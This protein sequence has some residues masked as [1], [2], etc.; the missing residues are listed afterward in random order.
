MPP[1]S[2]ETIHQTVEALKAAGPLPTQQTGFSWGSLS[3][4][5]TVASIVV[6]FLSVFFVFLPKWKDITNK[7][8]DTLDEERRADMAE[9]RKEVREIKTEL[10]AAMIRAAK[11]EASASLADTRTAILGGVISM[12][13]A[14]I[15]RT[16]PGNPVLKQA[17][18]M[19]KDA[20]SH[21]FGLGR[22]MEDI[23]AKV[24]GL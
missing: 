5:A 8:L 19:L 14:E 4:W 6:G 12:L 10:A 21:D 7:R 15:Q 22:G 20:A 13:T 1:V 2:P 17:Q 11:A 9:M 3:S 18:S 24:A 23:A 16:D